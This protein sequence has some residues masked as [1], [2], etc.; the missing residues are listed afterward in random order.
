MNLNKIPKPIKITVSALML[1]IVVTACMLG[2][3]LLEN[4]PDKPSK[5][6]TVSNNTLPPPPAEPVTQQTT[7]LQ[8]TVS[9]VHTTT[10]TTVTTTKTVAGFQPYVLKFANPAVSV[11]AEPD[12]SSEITTILD[13]RGSYTIIEETKDSYGNLW[14]KLQSGDG[15]IDL[16]SARKTVPETTTSEESEDG[17]D[18]EYTDYSDYDYSDY[19]DY[20]D[21]DYSEYYDYSDYSDYDYSDYSDD[22]YYYDDSYDYDYSDEW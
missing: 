1:L 19:S 5:T 21:Y 17:G 13:D 11:Y 12:Y 9:E 4:Q 15:W 20:S 7:A 16:I 18:D 3:S 10:A 22:G 14:G 8:T 6:M 2:I